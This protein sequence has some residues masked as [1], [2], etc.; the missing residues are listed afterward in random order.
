[1]WWDVDFYVLGLVGDVEVGD[2]GGG[3]VEEV[4]W[5]DDLVYLLYGVGLVVVVVD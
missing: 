4:V 2:G 1:M 5:F 3:M